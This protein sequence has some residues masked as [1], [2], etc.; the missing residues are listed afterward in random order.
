MPPPVR[1]R[2]LKLA[3]PGSFVVPDLTDDGLGVLAMQ[4]LPELTLTSTYYDSADLRLARSGVTLRYRTGEETGP[5]WTLKLPVAGHDALE[6]DEHTFQGSPDVIPLEAAE[7]VTALVRSAPIQPVASLETRRKRW[8]LCGA[9]DEALAE[10]ADDQ[11]TVLDGTR[12]VARFRELELESRGPD[13]VALRP[14]ANRLRRAGAVLA[15][16]VPKAVRALGPRASAAPDVTSVEVSPDDAAAK[17]VQAALSA[18][19]ARLIANDPPTRLGDVEGLHQMR[20]ATRR[21]RSDLRTFRPLIDE[22]WGRGLSDELRWLGDRLGAVRDP[23]VQL[24]HLSGTAADL[25]PG[26]DPY[27]QRLRDRQIAGRDALLEA[28]RSERYVGLLDRMVDAIRDPLVTDRAHRRS[29]GELPKLLRRAWKRLDQTASALSASDAEE[30]YHAVRIR[31]K[32]LRYAAEAIGPALGDRAAALARLAAAAADLQDLLGTMHDAVVTRIDL[33]ATLQ[34]ATGPDY[35]F[36]AGRLV[37]RCTA[38]VDEGRR[39]Y[40]RAW[41]RL[42]RRWRKA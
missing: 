37:E 33:H 15:E 8:M 34:E 22:R 3:A 29:R 42:L 13:L 1:E 40:P 6:R 25:R 16:P 26:I 27:L 11:V 35:A 4:E 23:D 21:L 24:G 38:A 14:I 36:A 20:V 10:L 7:L 18:G 28:L 2:E 41:K 32:R 39:R 12:V 19:L 30:S 31:A 5:A 9:D 17:A